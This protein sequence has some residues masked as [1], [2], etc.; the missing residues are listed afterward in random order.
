M[1]VHGG[2]IVNTGFRWQLSAEMR[3]GIQTTYDIAAHNLY[4]IANRLR[5]VQLLNLD[6]LDLIGRFRNA[7][8]AL[9]YFDPPYLKETRKRTNGYADFEVTRQW[10]ADAAELLR[11]HPGYVV[12]SGYA[13][14]LYREIYEGYGWQRVDSEPV[15]TNGGK[16]VESLWLNPATVDAL[17][18]EAH[19]RERESLPLLFFAAN[20][21]GHK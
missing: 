4:A 19:E 11:L 2:P 21:N 5:V 17:A 20:G 16:R 12:V 13:T 8:D 3:H 14:K 10:H 1:G 9:I 18:T 7:A 15:Q 6:A